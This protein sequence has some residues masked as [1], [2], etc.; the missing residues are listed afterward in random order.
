MSLRLTVTAIGS[1]AALAIIMWILIFQWPLDLL[2]NPASRYARW[3]AAHVSEVAKYRVFLDQRGVGTIVPMQQLLRLG[4]RWRQCGDEEF[5]LPPPEKWPRIVPTLQLLRDLRSQGL[6]DNGNV[7]S[8]FRPG[9]YNHCEGGSSGSRHLSNQALDI[10]LPPIQ[11]ERADRLCA[12]WRK[13]GARLGW[14][15][16]FYSPTEIHLDTAGF[17]TWGSDFHADTS[18]CQARR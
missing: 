17:R 3:Q 11:R 7:A 6:I 1:L 14:G 18:L 16:G 5:A 2:D 9:S 12:A 4:R 13:N 8:G 15:L 10:D